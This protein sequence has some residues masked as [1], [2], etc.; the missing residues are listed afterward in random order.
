MNGEPCTVQC[1][2]SYNCGHY[3]DL[4][5]H[6]DCYCDQYDNKDHT[7]NDSNTCDDQNTVS[8]SRK[9]SQNDDFGPHNDQNMVLNNRKYPQN[10]D[11]DTHYEQ[12]MVPINDDDTACDGVISHNG[13][14]TTYATADEWCTTSDLCAHY[15]QNMSPINDFRTHYDQN[16]DQD[17]DTV[18]SV[19]TTTINV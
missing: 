5:T 1:S 2:K 8:N 4:D 16:H 18:N 10:D 19:A 13:V 17:N 3:D 15:D 9:C 6:Y 12:N 14:D 11:F 7:I